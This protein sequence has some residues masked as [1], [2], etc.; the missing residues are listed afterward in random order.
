MRSIRSGNVAGMAAL[1][2]RARQYSA[3]GEYRKADALL[4]KGLRLAGPIGIV[5]GRDH[6]FLWNELGMVY[7]YL[8]K[9]KKSEQF[10]RLALRHAP[11]C[12]ERRERDFFLATLYHN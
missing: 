11:R 6:L 1:Q 3:R 7:K 10:Y 5:P 9:F 4:R 8:G 12:L 2:E